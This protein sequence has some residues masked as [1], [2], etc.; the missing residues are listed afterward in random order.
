MLSVFVCGAHEVV[1]PDVV[2]VELMQECVLML[3]VCV[4]GAHEV[5]CPDVVCVCVCGAH[6]GVCPDVVCVCGAHEVVCPDVVCVAGGS[7]WMIRLRAT[8]APPVIPASS[9]G[10]SP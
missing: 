2:C 3:C 7:C 1:C 4:C 6:A 5:V 8:S 10:R 9:G